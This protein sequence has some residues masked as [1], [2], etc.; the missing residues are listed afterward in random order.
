[1]PSD[2]TGSSIWNQRDGDFDFRAGPDLHELP[3]RRR[4]QPRAAEDAGGAARGDAGAA[5]HA[6]TARRTRSSRR[7]SSSPRRTRSSTRAPTRCPRR[8]ST[9]SCSGPRSATRAPRRSGRCSSG[10]SPGARTR[11]SSSRSSTG[12]TL[13]AM[14]SAVEDVHVSPSVGHYMV[15]LVRAH[16]RERER[17]RRRQPARVTGAAQALALPGRSRGP[18][19]RHAGRRQGGGA[20]RRS[21]TGS[22]SSRSSGCSGASAEDV[23]RTSSTRADA[24]GRG[25]PGRGVTAAL[26]AAPHLRGARRARPA[27]G[28]RD[29]AGPSWRSLAAPFARVLALGLAATARPVGFW[30]GAERAIEGDELNT[31]IESERRHR[32]RTAGARARAT[33]RA[34]GRRAT[35][36]SRVR[37]GGT[38]NGARAD[39]RSDAGAPGARRRVSAGTRPA[40]AL[41]LGGSDAARPPL[42]IYPRPE[43]LRRLVAPA[44]DQAYA[45]NEVARVQGRRS[46]VRRHSPLCPRRPAP[47]DQLAGERPAGELIVNERHPERNADVV[48]F[49]DSFAEARTLEGRARSTAPCGRRRPSPRCRSTA[50]T[51]SGSSPSAASC[52]G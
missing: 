50:A 29:C 22:C 30:L 17:R 3:P 12:K 19:L 14:Q 49:L 21:A 13:L 16:A 46:R 35:I 39:T 45:G 9:A 4:D 42:R 5:G 10:A 44:G 27:R 41:L 33:R 8:S 11:S 25:R 37:L 20:S 43:R 24:A 6:W 32:G 15:A 51:A 23:V 47:L 7:S 36:P 52:A 34:R 2:V 26:A 38:T 48:L 1:M 40:R 31:T 18:R 28:A